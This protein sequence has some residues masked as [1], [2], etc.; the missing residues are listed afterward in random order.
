MAIHL[1]VEPGS[2]TETWRR[3]LHQTDQARTIR[4][5]WDRDHTLWSRYP[6]GVLDRLGWLDAPE[7]MR[8]QLAEL[9]AFADELRNEGATRALI[10]GMGGASLAAEMLREG[11]GVRD[12]FLDV[13]VVDST[14]PDELR[15][16]LARTR[17]ERTVL[18]LSM[19]AWALESYAIFVHLYRAF[20]KTLGVAGTNRRVVVLTDPDAWVLPFARRHGFRR[21]FVNDPFVGGRYAAHTFV[22]LLPAA[23]LG[24]DLDAFLER[25][26]SAR[27]RCRPDAEQTSPFGTALGAF[28]GD[29]ANAGRNK[30]TFFA[31]PELRGFVGW[32]EQLLAES[33]GKDGRGVVPVVGGPE[34]P[35]ERYGVDRTFVMLSVGRR[36]ANEERLADSDDAGGGDRALGDRATALARHGQPVVRLHLDD[37]AD[38]SGLCFAWMVA[39][40]VAGHRMGVQPF[41]Q[42]NVEATKARTA[43]LLHTDT[44]TATESPV[45]ASDR[46]DEMSTDPWLLSADVDPG[47]VADAVAAFA[48]QI[49][50]YGYLAVQAFVP[51]DRGV[52]ESLTDVVR[53]LERTSDR[54]MTVGIGPRFLHSTGQLHKGDAGRGRFLQITATPTARPPVRTTLDGTVS[55]YDFATLLLAQAAGDAAALRSADR[56]VFRIHIEG[57]PEA[58]L[59]ALAV[60]LSDATAIADDSVG[61]DAVS[62]ATS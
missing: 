10:V 39:T 38:V 1:D 59:R 36:P 33:L 51:R 25:A 7:A 9:R 17:P 15:A 48:T 43:I 14:H 53:A 35:A 21:V 31:P 8:T 57:A 42:P 30:I 47:R 50:P 34:R 44:A 32:V 23:L 13:D 27:E 60:A 24:V 11:Y 58:L 55:D 18:V 49:D 41:D 22:G 20:V 5:L 6:V 29:L 26:A 56:T 52:M 12:G 46:A 54:P 61:D 2:C 45:T 28:V 62:D 40:A 19:K 3:A 4:R 37:I 16:V